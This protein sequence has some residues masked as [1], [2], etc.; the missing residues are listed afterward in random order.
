M[1]QP[2]EPPQGQFTIFHCL[3][4]AII[5]LSAMQA[6]IWGGL[7]YGLWGFICGVPIGAVLGF[8]GWYAIVWFVLGIG[9]TVI[10]VKHGR[11][12]ADEFLWGTDDA[13][14]DETNTSAG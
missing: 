5:V 10:R 1:N 4:L 14:P 11:K 13:P 9:W 2:A 3:P 6:G 12:A 8:V 7:W